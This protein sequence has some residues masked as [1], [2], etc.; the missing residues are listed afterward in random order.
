MV[1]EGGRSRGS[2]VRWLVVMMMVAVVV[3]A[4][5]MAVVVYLVGVGLLR[6]PRAV[7]PKCLRLTKGRWYQK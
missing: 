3:V 6:L 5:A 7:L 1:V 4:I 2:D